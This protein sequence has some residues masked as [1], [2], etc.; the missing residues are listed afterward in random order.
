MGGLRHRSRTRRTDVPQDQATTDP[1]QR[2]S[3]V[4]GTVVAGLIGGAHAMFGSVLWA[5][6]HEFGNQSLLLTPLVAAEK[7]PL[8]LP[9]DGDPDQATPVVVRAGS[10]RTSDTALARDDRPTRPVGQAASRAIRPLDGAPRREV[11]TVVP[12]EPPTTAGR[13]RASGPAINT[14]PFARRSLPAAPKSP[15]LKVRAAAP[16][17]PATPGISDEAPQSGSVATLAP[18]PA[19]KPLD[20]IPTLVAEATPAPAAASAAKAADLAASAIRPP[21][22]WLKPIVLPS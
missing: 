18:A 13:D 6:Y 10:D 5:A 1:K 20:A 4:R 12:A 21:R 15:P 7:T 22:P 14:V 11:H 2:R 9:P 3:Y 16:V 8:K 19:L 17:E